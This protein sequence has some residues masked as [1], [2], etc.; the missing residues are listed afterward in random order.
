LGTAQASHS[1]RLVVNIVV[2][3][4][5]IDF[6]ILSMVGRFFFLFILVFV[7]ASL[8]LAGT[9]LEPFD[10]MAA[11]IATLGNVGPGF[12]IV[13]PAVNYAPITPFGKVTLTLCMLLG[14]LELF[15]LLVL[16]QPEFWKSKKSW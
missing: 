5:V 2:Q 14:R 8:L 13:G 1:S 6:Y 15:T 9:G 3:D 11:V 4:K 10:A 12:G 16:L 7:C